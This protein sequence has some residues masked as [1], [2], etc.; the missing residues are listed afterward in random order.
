[1]PKHTKPP[2]EAM[3][4]A[5]ALMRKLGGFDETRIEH[6]EKL[7]QASAL[8]ADVH[9][10]TFD[11]EGKIFKTGVLYR[12]YTTVH[13]AALNLFQRE[14]APAIAARQAEDTSKVP[15]TRVRNMV[16]D[17]VKIRSRYSKSIELVLMSEV[18]SEL[19]DTMTPAM[20]E[21]WSDSAPRPHYKIGLRPELN[22]SIDANELADN[23]DKLFLGHAGGHNGIEIFDCDLNDQDEEGAQV[24][25]SRAPRWPEGDLGLEPPKG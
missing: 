24:L 17:G 21:I 4:A 10:S 5:P 12:T 2:A 13:L 1:M 18:I 22:G 23:L 3:A 6:L 15:T 14:I 7:M 25:A 19:P 20:T 8:I 11:H 16:V 9:F